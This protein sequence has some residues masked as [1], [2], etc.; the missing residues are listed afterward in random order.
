METVGGNLK[1]VM[2]GIG[3]EYGW[4]EN[5]P[6][7]W[8][9][10]CIARCLVEVISSETTFDFVLFSPAG[11][12]ILPPAAKEQNKDE[13]VQKGAFGTRVALCGD[14]VK[15]AGCR[16]RRGKWC[17]IFCVSHNTHQ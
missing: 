14:N 17:L 3:R 5:M 16:L 13:V 10:R 15:Q 12:S 2:L 6:T 11:S 7:C 1:A 4:V 9:T 8:H